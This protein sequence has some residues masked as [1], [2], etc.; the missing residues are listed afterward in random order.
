MLKISKLVLAS[1]SNVCNNVKNWDAF[2]L[3]LSVFSGNGSSINVLDSGRIGKL[4]LHIFFEDLL[5]CL[6][7]PCLWRALKVGCKW[8]ELHVI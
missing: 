3:I 6:V 1:Y 7:W 2:A 8:S 4:Y 5:H